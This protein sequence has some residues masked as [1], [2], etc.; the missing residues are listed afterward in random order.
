VF[1]I[2]MIRSMS[3]FPIV[4]A[5]ANPEPEIDYNE[6]HESRN[7][8]IFATSLDRYPNAIV[9]LLSC[10]YI[11]RG[12]LDVQA[13]RITE[14][15]MLA[16]ARSLAE[17]AREEMVEEVESAYG[18]KRFT[19]GPEYL[20]PKPI[21][22]RIFV[23][24]T[25]AV[26]RQASLDK[27]AGR[28]I[29]QEFYQEQLVIRR[30]TGRET[31]RGLMLR[32]RRQNLR[33][34]FS[35]GCNDTILRA[36]NVLIDEGIARPILLGPEGEIRNRSDDLG[37]NLAAATVV[38]PAHCAHFDHYVD[39]YFK[40][41]WRH[42]V[43]RAAAAERIRLADRFAAMMLHA[44]DADAMIAGF[45]THYVD[46]LRTIIE[47]IGPAEGVKQIAGHHLVLLPK[48]LVI[49]ADCAINI[50]PDV[51]DLAEIALQ[52]ARLVKMLGI[53][54][55]V[56]MLSF[57]N[58]GSVRHPIAEKMRRAAD[59]AREKWSDLDIDGEM[60]LTVARNSAMRHE[61]FPLSHLEKD[62]NVLVAPDLQSG[63]ITMHALHSIGEAKSI[64]TIIL[65]TRLPAHLLSYGA[66]VEDVV[67]LTAVAVVEAAERI[68]R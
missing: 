34:V 18:N 64:G 12:A 35:E 3:R 50:N 52:A 56:A 25:A 30:G 20:I 1:D 60:Q 62:A 61:Y 28:K 54:P 7:D 31:I 45:S 10:P 32:A 42:G 58:F 59:L 38:D 43:M 49:V 46:T 14:D 67:N 21:D 39:E 15:M 9:D 63:N 5:M 29:E 37:L 48:D 6:A 2:K 47:V 27:V 36:A 23:R 16:A 57:S 22:P 8:L 40:M 66:R 26:V 55:H 65:G 51:E 24:E 4:F 17:L 33:V 44:G 68:A 13:S 19:F 11:L 41:R 53:E